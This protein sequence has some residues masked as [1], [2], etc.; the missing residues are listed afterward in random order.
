MLVGVQMTFPTPWGVFKQWEMKGVQVEGIQ[1]EWDEYESSESGEE[2]EFGGSA[3]KGEDESGSCSRTVVIIVT[4]SGYYTGR[5]RSG[6]G[7]LR[8]ETVLSMKGVK[9]E[10]WLARGGWQQSCSSTTHRRGGRGKECC[11]SLSS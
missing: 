7:S 8:E 9:K 2:S 3:S 1:V 5:W 6:R 4:P 11:T 10:W